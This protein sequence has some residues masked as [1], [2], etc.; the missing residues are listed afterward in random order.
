MSII[1]HVDVYY[2]LYKIHYKLWNF[3]CPHLPLFDGFKSFNLLS[4][5]FLF[6]IKGLSVKY[7]CFFIQFLVIPIT[8]E[9]NCSSRIVLRIYHSINPRLDHCRVVLQNTVRRATNSGDT[10]CNDWP[11]IDVGCQ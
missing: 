1:S 11:R 8:G 4:Y 9:P 10:G 6:N 7:F 3:V 5:G 2:R